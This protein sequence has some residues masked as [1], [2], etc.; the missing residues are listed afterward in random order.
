MAIKIK[1]PFPPT[2]GLEDSHHHGGG[3]ANPEVVGAR[4]G[5]IKGTRNLPEEILNGSLVQTRKMYRL[6]RSDP[7]QVYLTVT[8][9]PEDVMDLWEREGITN[10]PPNP[11]QWGVDESFLS[12]ITPS[13]EQ[14]HLKALNETGVLVPDYLWYVVQTIVNHINSQ[15]TGDVIYFIVLEFVIHLRW[16]TLLLSPEAQMIKEESREAQI[17]TMLKSYY[18][19]IFSDLLAIPNTCFLLPVGREPNEIAVLP[20]DGIKVIPI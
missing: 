4:F 1:N 2:P 17:L 10:Y 16:K 18:Q 13:E 6:R 20:P 15:E 8:G 19:E 11:L 3:P 7:N 14:L 9:V 12:T 5:P